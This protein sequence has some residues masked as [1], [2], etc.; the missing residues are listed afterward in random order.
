MK[1]VR[2]IAGGLIYL[3]VWTGMISVFFAAVAGML[4]E[5]E[6][7]GWWVGG[8]LIGIAMLAVAW[9]I[10]WANEDCLS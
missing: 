6:R 3:A 10:G 9:I 7:Y 5:I 2:R 1:T 4:L 8:P